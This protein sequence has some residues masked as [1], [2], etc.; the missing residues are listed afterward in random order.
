MN[1]SLEFNYPFKKINSPIKILKE[2]NNKYIFPISW[3]HTQQYCECI[4]YLWLL[5]YSPKKVKNNI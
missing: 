3:L 5:G 4:F 2:I 1:Q